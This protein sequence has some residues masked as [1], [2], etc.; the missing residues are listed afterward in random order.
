MK[1]AFEIARSKTDDAVVTKYQHS[2]VILD[3]KGRVISTGKNHWAGN[4][5]IADDDAD[6]T[7]KKTVHAEI[8][9]LTKVN[10]RRLR[11][12]TIINYAKTNVASNN[13]RPCENCWPILKKLGFRKVF[14]SV[15]SP[16]DKPVWK[17][18]YF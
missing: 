18:E 10:I 7:I 14:Y 3:R 15:R 9:A 6:K 12:A 2:S 8:N 5:V 13:A 11:G 4:L 1:D 16:L 17:E